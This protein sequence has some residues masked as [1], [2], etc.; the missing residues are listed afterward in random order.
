MDNLYSA[1]I[2]KK[3]VNGL[4]R[5]GDVIEARVTSVKEDGKLDLS[6]R[7]KIPEQM[8]QDAELILQRIERLWRK[9]A[10]Y[11]QGRA[12]ADSAGV[13]NSK[14]AFKRAVGRLLKERRIEIREDGILL[15]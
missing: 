12:A 9:I 14:A 3:D 10:I 2:P 11:R 6:V 8:N 4:L 15:K 5:V 13:W 7:G 1:R